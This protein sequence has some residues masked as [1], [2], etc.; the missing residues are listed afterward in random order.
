MKI[1]SSLLL[2]LLLAMIALIPCGW[3][4]EGKT[5][6]TGEVPSAFAM[7]VAEIESGGVRI[8]GGAALKQLIE[9]NGNWKTEGDRLYQNDPNETQA[10]ALIGNFEWFDS[11]IKAKVVF[12]SWA[13]DPNAA[14][15]ILLRADDKAQSFTSVSLYPQIH[16]VAIEQVPTRPEQVSNNQGL[17]TLRSFRGASKHAT[18][19]T[20]VDAHGRDARVDFHIEKDRAYELEVVVDHAA[21]YCFIDGEFITAGRVPDL[22]SN[23]TGRTGFGTANLAAEFS[24]ISVKPL[25]IPESPFREI[26]ECTGYE[27]G[28][29]TKGIW[30][31]STI[32][33]EGKYKTWCTSIGHP[34]D[35]GYTESLDGIHWTQEILCRGMGLKP[36]QPGVWGN[37]GCPDPEVIKYQGKYW[38]FYP[39]ITSSTPDYGKDSNGTYKWD[40]MGIAFSDDGIDWHPYKHNPVLHKGPEGSWDSECIGD[41][42]FIRDGNL[43]KVWFC[44]INEPSAGFNNE[45]GYAES[46]DGI[47]WKKLRQNPVLRQGEPGEWDGD[48]I[49]AATVIKLQDEELASGVYRGNEGSYHM[50]Y[51]GWPM[52]IE[53]VP[54][55]QRIGYAFS[56]DG[57]NWVKYRAPNTESPPY[58][59]SAPVITWAPYGS[60]GSGGYHACSAVRVGDEVKMWVYAWNLLDGGVMWNGREDY[61]NARGRT[62]LATAKVSDLLAIVE[63]AKRDGLLKQSSR[64]EI[65]AQLVDS[66]PEVSVER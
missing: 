6:A 32:Y 47:Q 43:F 22:A 29:I 56:L 7:K 60:Y 49:S 10:K 33:D 53:S 64:S 58:R 57:I 17:I 23:P 25:P 35:M 11:V 24:D 62:L 50:F 8:D 2:S 27:S 66:K 48:W 21:I 13:D 39:A 41:H 44:G 55:L 54:G 3:A 5:D 1:Q 28:G 61:A 19:E 65:E 12:R 51:T 20:L 45:F 52:S 15:R 42:G 31:P 26:K 4:A 63:K 34:K 40:G 16:E 37:I 30:S 59:H 46:E 9:V 38:C 18:G 36:N 14:L